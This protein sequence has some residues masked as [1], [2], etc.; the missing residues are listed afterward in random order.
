[1]TA[2][3]PSRAPVPFMADELPASLTAPTDAFRYAIL[4]ADPAALYGFTT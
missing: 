3:A 4:V 2:S 1:M